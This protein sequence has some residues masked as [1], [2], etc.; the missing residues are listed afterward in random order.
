MRVWDCYSLLGDLG[1]DAFTTVI[2]NLIAIEV[3]NATRK[4]VTDRICSLAPSVT[5]SKFLVEWDPSSWSRVKR[6]K[7]HHCSHLKTGCISSAHSLELYRGW[8]STSKATSKVPILFTQCD[9]P[10][11]DYTRKFGY[12]YFSLHISER[13]FKEFCVSLLS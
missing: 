12:Y 6:V 5:S 9:A 13:G 4:R 7:N 1:F 2:S 8:R 11:F 3:E 10:W